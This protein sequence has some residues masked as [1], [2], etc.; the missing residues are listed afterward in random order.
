MSIYVKFSNIAFGLIIFVQA[1]TQSYPAIEVNFGLY[2][3]NRNLNITGYGNGSS[4]NTWI[5][6]GVKNEDWRINYVSDSVFEIVNSSTGLL[7]TENNDAAVIAT[8]TFDKN[9]KW[10]I[11]GIDTDF[12][13]AFLYY[14]IISVPGG[15]ALTLNPKGNRIYLKQ[16]TGDSLQKWRIDLD[17][18][19]GFA[20]NC[21]ASKGIK[22][23]TIGGALGKTVF[24]STITELKQALLDSAA[25]TVVLTADIDCQNQGADFRFTSNKTL[26]GSYTANKLLDVRFR[27]NDSDQLLPP[28]DNIV[29]RNMTFG[30]EKVTNWIVIQIYSSKNIW[31]DH[32]TFYSTL[33]KNVDEVGKFIWINTP[34][35][36]KDISRSPDFVTLSYN[37]FRNRYWC[38]AYGTQNSMITENRTTV[39]YNFWDSNVRRTP[40]IGNGSLHT[41]NNFHLRN[42]TSTDNAGLANIIPGEGS[43]VYSE[44]N[45]FEGFRH[46]SSG[47]WDNEVEID[48]K[49]AF[50]DTGS[51]TNKSESGTSAT[52]PYLWSTTASYTKTSWIPS[53]HYGYKIIKA[54]SETG[55]SDVKAFC[56]N[57]TGCK[58]AYSEI[59]YI[60]DADLAPYVA[61]TAANPFYSQI[62]VTEID[63]TFVTSDIGKKNNKNVPLH[64]QYSNQN[65]KIQSDNAEIIKK[66]E[67]YNLAGTRLLTQMCNSTVVSINIKS[68]DWGL[69]IMTIQTNSHIYRH[70]FQFF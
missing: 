58:S 42:T 53:E 6:N 64:I 35:S 40:Q 11:I 3:S 50:T 49:A 18:L 14:K 32:C 56:E 13:G 10:R 57:I 39:M 20:A 68:L 7:L 4:C 51:Y 69:F 54:F 43:V 17:G 19:Q 15:K 55:N 30:V 24:V 63:P 8:K 34:Y 2:N 29:I 67:I 9:Q 22:A 36:G 37:I 45:R 38:I 52:T 46:E 31:V 1:A 33:T 21:K 28:G 61:R 25:L 12:L 65:C 27:T 5:T 44:S 41:Y 62:S 60:T 48:S 66:I 47:Y 70:R 23:G 59:H 16:F 26:I